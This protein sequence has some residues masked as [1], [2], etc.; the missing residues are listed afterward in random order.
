MHYS[1]VQL[2]FPAGFTNPLDNFTCVIDRLSDATKPSVVLRWDWAIPMDEH[3]L[4][5]TSFYAL[6]IFEASGID[7][8]ITYSIGRVTN[9]TIDLEE[10]D[11]Y[12]FIVYFDCENSVVSVANCTVN[13][14]QQR[15]KE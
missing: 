12:T 13:T 10:E 8:N 15:C 5:E 3:F 2:W 4:N 1:E 6:V 11:K 14:L 7:N 9:K